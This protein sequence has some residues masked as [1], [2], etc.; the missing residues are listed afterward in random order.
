MTYTQ[1]CYF[2]DEENNVKNGI[3]ATVVIE[4]HYSLEIRNFLF[5]I[6]IILW[7]SKEQKIAEY[8]TKDENTLYHNLSDISYAMAETIK[9]NE[10]DKKIKRIAIRALCRTCGTVMVNKILTF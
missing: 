4:S 2:D 3:Y 7:N 1:A 9:S 8:N 6:K 5:N 10:S